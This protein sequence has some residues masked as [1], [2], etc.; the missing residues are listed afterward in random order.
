MADLMEIGPRMLVGD[1]DARLAR[2][3]SLRAAFPQE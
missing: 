2:F 3:S 1:V